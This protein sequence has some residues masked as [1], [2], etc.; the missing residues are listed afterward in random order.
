MTSK[1]KCTNCNIV[2][3]EMLAYIQNKLSIMDEDSLV[4]IC[5]SAFT[6]KQI[7]N[8]KLLL[9]ES[10]PSEKRKQSRKGQGKESRELNDIIN[11]FKITDPDVIPI[12]VARDLEKLP[13]ITF[14]HLD[15]TK[16]LKDITLLQNE[17]KV[18]QSS[19]VTVQQLEEV[20]LDLHNMKYASLPMSPCNV[21]MMGRGAYHDSGPVG[22]SCFNLSPDE[23]STKESQLS[24]KHHDKSELNKS[25][26]DQEHQRV[27]FVPIVAANADSES[28]RHARARS[29]SMDTE[30]AAAAAAT[31]PALPCPA[32]AD[33]ASCAAVSIEPI[34]DGCKQKQFADVLKEKDLKKPVS[35]GEWTTV[36]RKRRSKMS[37]RYHGHMGVATDT[38]DKF[39]AA[40]KKVPIFIT[41]VHKG[42]KEIDITS[43][44]HT[45]TQENVK[46]EKIV[47]K[48]DSDHD[49][50]KFYVSELKLST[51]L[52]EN[53][54]PKGIIFRRFVHF[55]YKTRPEGDLG[56]G[57]I[58]QKY[59]C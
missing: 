57:V 9:F 32:A 27:D 58:K 59:V 44:I 1:V 30:R 45:K 10:L 6:K 18:I 26:S 19:Y 40:E 13:P 34:Y 55:K 4:R 12:F 5:V 28:S 54:W 17:V 22:M 53:L 8:S 33:N 35:D 56:D 38:N 41:N 23:N 2:I 46:L 24:P 16:L 7:E 50:Y 42:T 20:K 21:N 49:A 37:Y 15:V 36:E 29:V 51:F 14:D 25:K 3:D 11:L 31:V 52:D 39:R 47:M 43:Y 48:T